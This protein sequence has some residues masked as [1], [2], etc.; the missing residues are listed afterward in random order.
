[1]GLYFNQGKDAN[2]YTDSK[3]AFRVAH[4][5]GMLWKQCDFFTS[6]KN[7]TKNVPY[8]QKLLNAIF[9]LA[10]LAITKIPG[11]SKLDC[12]EV[13]GNH[14]ADILTRAAFLKGTNGSQT[15]VMVKS[16]IFPKL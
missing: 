2:I 6:R 7:K 10:T 5:F 16:D 14:P 13:R 1:M 15:A 4:D 11:N 3:Y 8:V 12:P 9:L